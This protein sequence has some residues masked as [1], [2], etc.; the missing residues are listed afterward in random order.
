MEVRAVVLDNYSIPQ[1]YNSNT[2][3]YNGRETEIQPGAGTG[4]VYIEQSENGQGVTTVIT[5]QSTGSLSI[6]IYFYPTNIK[7][8]HNNPQQ[9]NKE[10]DDVW[11]AWQDRNATVSNR[12]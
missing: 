3:R 11:F 10:A 7:I 2:Q 1:K 8:V 6:A 5:I 9:I 4:E 12:P